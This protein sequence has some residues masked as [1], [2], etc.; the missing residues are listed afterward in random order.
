MF[1]WVGSDCSLN[2]MPLAQKMSV[3]YL[4]ATSRPTRAKTKRKEE[5]DLRAK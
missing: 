4:P 5:K 1:D 3:F 2:A